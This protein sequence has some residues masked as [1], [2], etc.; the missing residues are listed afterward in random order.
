MTT[1][2]ILKDKHPHHCYLLRKLLFLLSSYNYGGSHRGKIPRSTSSTTTTTATTTTKLYIRFH[3]ISIF[4]LLLLSLSTLTDGHQSIETLSSSSSTTEA[5][6]SLPTTTL[7]MN[8]SNDDTIITTTEL[9][10]DDDNNNNNNV[11]VDDDDENQ[12]IPKTEAIIATTTFKNIIPN[13]STVDDNNHN[14]NDLLPLATMT[15]TA[16]STTTTTLKSNQIFNQS[17]II[18]NDNNVNIDCFQFDQIVEKYPLNQICHENIEIDG[19]Y[20]NKHLSFIKENNGL[21]NNLTKLIS[22]Y[23]HCHIISG[24]VS[25]RHFYFNQN[26]SLLINLVFPNLE[27]IR[28]FLL[29]HNFRSINDDLN[30][31]ITLGHIFPRLK[32]IYGYRR[33]DNIALTISNFWTSDHISI[34]SLQQ[35]CGTVKIL[36]SRPYFRHSST[37]W[38]LVD[39]YRNRKLFTKMARFQ[40]NYLIPIRTIN[41]DENGSNI[42]GF[43][44]RLRFDNIISTIKRRI[45][46]IL[47]A[48]IYEIDPTFYSF[49]ETG[50]RR[51]TFFCNISSRIVILSDLDYSDKQFLFPYHT[52]SFDQ[53]NFPYWKT[54][55][56]YE[57]F[58]NESHIH[59]AHFLY[60]RRLDNIDIC[61]LHNIYYDDNYNNDKHQSMM[62]TN[63]TY[64]FQFEHFYVIKLE[65]CVD[66]RHE[67]CIV[68]QHYI[69]NPKYDDFEQILFKIQHE[70]NGNWILK[71]IIIIISILTLSIIGLFICCQRQIRLYRLFGLKSF[72]NMDVISVN[73]DYGN[74]SNNNHHTDHS[75]HF[76]STTFHYGPQQ[77]LSSSSSSSIIT[78]DNITCEINRQSLKLN[79]QK[80]LGK[81]EFGIV[82]EGLLLLDHDLGC[83]YHR[84]AGSKTLEEESSENSISSCTCMTQSNPNNDNIPSIRVAIKQLKDNGFTGSGAII[85]KEK[86]IQEA[87]FMKTFNSNFLVKLLGVSTAVEP[88]L[89]VMEYME[90]ND[91]KR[92]L[93]Q[94]YQ[95]YLKSRNNDL[96]PS[97]DQ[98][99]RM[100]IQIAD[101]MHY[102]HSKRV[103]HRDL[104]ARNCMVA[105]DLTVKI[106][107]FGL[108]RD[109]YEKDYYRLS[110]ETPMPLRWMA[111][112]SIRNQVFTPYSDV[113]SY[114]VVLWEIMSFGEQPYHG[115]SDMEVK[116]LLSNNGRLS[117]PLYYFEP[118]W[119]IAK[120]CWCKRPTQ[121][122][123]FG[124]IIEMLYPHLS[125]NRD[126]FDN[127]SYY[128]S[129]RMGSYVKYSTFGLMI[130][131]CFSCV[132]NLCSSNKSPSS[133]NRQSSMFT[134][135][136]A[137]SASISQPL[138]NQ[139]QNQQQQ[140]RR[141]TN[142][143][144]QSTST[145]IDCG[146]SKL[147]LRFQKKKP[148]LLSSS[149]FKR[150]HRQFS[151]CS[152]STNA[153]TATTTTTNNVDQ[154]IMMNM[155]YPSPTST[156]SQL[157]LPPPSS[158]ITCSSQTLQSHP[159]LSNIWNN[160]PIPNLP[161]SVTIPY[162]SW[163]QMNSNNHSNFFPLMAQQHYNHHHHHPQQQQYSSM[164]SLPSSS[165]TDTQT[166]ITTLTSSGHHHYP[167]PYNQLLF[168]NH[169][170]PQQQQLLVDDN[171]NYEIMSA[172]G[173]I[174]CTMNAEAAVT[175]DDNDDDDDDVISKE[176]PEI[177]STMPL[178]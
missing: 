72:V 54:N 42:I 114:G 140:Q 113:W 103:I 57:S 58:K 175:A 171:C 163:I 152:S 13:L 135:T 12:I 143:S 95:D 121:R 139:N 69:F 154:M 178:I 99:A 74:M 52:N 111:P 128:V 173:A 1:M 88:I 17:S 43:D 134:S 172:G 104:A 169:Q 105:A 6:S 48:S 35:V 106:G 138:L 70:M 20:F 158:L 131:H 86:F 32:R 98:L 53:K 162:G 46:P 94:R 130:N 87:K 25:L 82:Y 61:R 14:N 133:K 79:P 127:L 109:L 3:P 120:L 60:N 24:F 4:I 144:Q 153:T 168:H 75:N 90:H 145:I 160:H 11:D 19:R 81:G 33:I 137:A 132:W 44:S 65:F 51:S 39:R 77:P 115:R 157:Q 23:E 170:Y 45:Y 38:H 37:Y 85:N 36:E 47:H 50:D 146:C 22:Q 100:A 161:S 29:I 150:L 122:P 26:D 7:M 123:C 151:T 92:F 55:N 27:F 78:N 125:T 80:T 164:E 149:P 119:E 40:S 64:P 136:S 30:V 174:S 110:E 62:I 67:K 177:S 155:V 28:D 15:S 16:A 59:P 167:H 96:L 117:R 31:N 142:S 141:D 5:T 165:I 41:D 124:E 129:S 68:H 21:P 176:N 147:P 91:L 107:D 166:D 56:L 18:V 2:A 34:D 159:P 156:S 118:L 93:R 89:V 148:L 116:K 83:S 10:L 126:Q 108:T 63:E 76:W 97:F 71:T 73:P 112:E 102:L 8:I 84:L 66:R 49:V 101:G 9:L